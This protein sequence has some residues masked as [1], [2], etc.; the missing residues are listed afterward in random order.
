MDLAD[1][2][3]FGRMGLGSACECGR[4]SMKRAKGRKGRRDC[5]GRFGGP[6]GRVLDG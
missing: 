4:R 1:H 3:G 6:F 2:L 5:L